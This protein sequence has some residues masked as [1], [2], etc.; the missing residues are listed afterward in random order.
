MTSDELRRLILSLISLPKETE[1]FE[2][3]RDKTIPQEMGEY[4]SALANSAALLGEPN[5][6]IVWGRGGSIP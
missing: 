3:K 5:A 4:V 1:W 2:F 6:Y